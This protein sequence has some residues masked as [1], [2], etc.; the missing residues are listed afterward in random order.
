MRRWYVSDVMTRDVVSVPATAGYKQMADLLVGHRIS[1]LPVVDG[2]R[3]VLGVVSEADL[4]AKL[5]CADRV[6]RHPLATRRARNGRRKATGDTAAELMTSPAVTVSRTE[7]VTR[8]AR[9]MEAARVKRV[10]VVDPGGH[11]IGI[12]SRRDLVRMYT[13][14]DQEIRADVG[15]GVLRSLWIDPG[16]LQIGVRSGIVTLTGKVDRRST[17]EIG[18][19]FVRAIPGVVD[20]VDQLSWTLDDRASAA[21]G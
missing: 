12:V 10:P 6:P 19:A 20:V 14:S 18:V 2:E 15:Q 4:L 17:A 5:E 8:V 16:Q 7:T 3:R 1:A 9:L 21:F 11:L 13:R